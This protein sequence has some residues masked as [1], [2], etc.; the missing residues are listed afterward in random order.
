MPICTIDS[1]V[2]NDKTVGNLTDMGLSI[3]APL[4][5]RN[6]GAFVTT[7]P[8]GHTYSCQSFPDKW[9]ELVGADINVTDSNVI[10]DGLVN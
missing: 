5:G 4:C 2:L 9:T 8:D 7:P 1:N 6:R 10:K 3:F